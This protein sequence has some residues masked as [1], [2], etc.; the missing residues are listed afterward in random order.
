MPTNNLGAD[1]VPG[2]FHFSWKDTGATA[3]C[4][5]QRFIFPQSLEVVWWEEPYSCSPLNPKIFPNLLRSR[6][7]ELSPKNSSIILCND[8]LD[9]LFIFKAEV[10][11]HIWTDLAG[12]TRVFLPDVLTICH[13]ALRL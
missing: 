11:E 2:D 8:V 1:I 9:I 10:I 7:I 4:Q 5:V 3:V 6:L 12:M 13:L